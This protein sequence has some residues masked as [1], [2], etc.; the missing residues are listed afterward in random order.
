MPNKESCFTPCG[1]SITNPI[2]QCKVGYAVYPARL[3][4]TTQ[5]LEKAS[6]SEEALQTPPK[7]IK[8]A[9]ANQQYDLRRLRD[10]FIYLLAT[11]ASKEFITA[12][13]PN[14][15]A[16]YIYR[17]RSPDIDA[18]DNHLG[19]LPIDY[20]FKQYQCENQD[21][22]QAWQ[23]GT[24]QKP[25][26]LLP[27]S[28]NNIEILYS[29]FE[30][31]LELLD[32]LAT[33][34]G[35]RGRW[36]RKANIKTPTGAAA[37]ITELTDLVQ[38]FN[39]TAK[40]IIKEP[41]KAKRFTPIGLCN[42]HDNL[43]NLIVSHGKGA[44]IA[45]DDAIGTARD[46]AAYHQYLE[47]QRQA[48]L[49]KYE[50]AIVTAQLIDA[51]AKQKLTDYN[52]SL[53][54]QKSY[55][56]HTMR[57]YPEK[58]IDLSGAYK[59]I[60]HI[61]KQ[62]INVK[63]NDITRAL[64]DEFEL[65]DDLP[66]VN[67]V[68]CIANVSGQ[69]GKPFLN[70]TTVQAELAKENLAR[71]TD[72]LALVTEEMIAPANAL[73]LYLHGLL[74]GIN[75]TTYGRQGL[76]MALDKTSEL[77]KDKEKST[78]T[79]I[80]DSLSE[81]VK[82]FKD[83]TGTL[84]AVSNLTALHLYSYDKVITVLVTEVTLSN[85]HVKQSSEKGKGGKGSMTFYEETTLQTEIKTIYRTKGIVPR[86]EVF[87][88][89]R[90]I[91]R[92]VQ[93][94]Y[95]VV[96]EGRPTGGSIDSAKQSLV[97]ND[98]SYHLFKTAGDKL[99]GA[100][101]YF[102]LMGSIMLFFK[103]N[104]AKTTAGRIAN[105]AVLNTVASLAEVLKP[106]DKVTLSIIKDSGKMMPVNAITKQPFTSNWSLARA[107]ILNFSTGLA[108]LGVLMEYFNMREA[109]YNGD[110]WDYWGSAAKGAG[111][112]M[113]ALSPVVKSLMAA[114]L[115]TGISGA[116]GVVGAT[117]TGVGLLLLV[118]GFIAV[119]LKKSDM[120]SWIYYGFWG[121]SKKYWGEPLD[122]YEWSGDRPENFQTYVFNNSLFDYLNDKLTLEAQIA[123]DDY[124]IEMQRFYAFADKAI[125]TK[126]DNRTLKLQYLGLTNAEITKQVKLSLLKF[127]LIGGPYVEYVVNANEVAVQFEEEGLAFIHLP[128]QWKGRYLTPVRTPHGV[129]E[130]YEYKTFTSKQINNIAAIAEVPRYKN[131]KEYIEAT[132]NFTDNR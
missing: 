120:E 69:Y 61:D 107:G 26:I 79:T 109:D 7:T 51:Y 38:D 89:S 102:G 88:E 41:G 108:G 2:G 63:H 42:H 115:A 39:I 97:I 15:Q 5:Q 114:S 59:K 37:P 22:R 126:V 62:H 81:V 48:K 90:E 52:R 105:N 29:D 18:A 64:K 58:P 9:T 60:S 19:D 53:R 34:E 100:S 45:L 32:T 43:A 68:N 78:I 46:L 49:K 25:F 83:L 54:N 113:L 116:A 85:L 31:P 103:E 71:L 77:V 76:L 30:L 95:R 40:P 73:C 98:D 56:D 127:K 99:A 11:N 6:Q 101:M 111:L 13:A 21:I 106:A 118:A 12:K 4:I 121:D 23:L 119:A 67:V 132:L 82:V 91:N 20:Y 92:T 27:E 125:L 65:L 55:S 131:E 47:E 80:T 3:A 130:Q 117:L 94:F 35:V 36:M 66:G 110:D 96:P 10:G 14:N 75:L 28:I 1:N 84:A 33:N 50:Y 129:F 72:L 104:D 123:Y 124:Q 17:Y 16:W 128:T 8:E 70:V 112:T 87:S 86:T 122:G 93:S 44:I 74:W 57:P 24:A